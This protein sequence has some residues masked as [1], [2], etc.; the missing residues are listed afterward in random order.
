M[1]TLVTVTLL[2]SVLAVVNTLVLSLSPDRYRRE[3]RAMLSLMSLA[4]I[5]S[6]LLG[7]DFSDISSRF[8]DIALP[9]MSIKRDEAITSELDKK[10]QEYLFTCLAEKGIAPENIFI[11]TTIDAERR[12]FITKARIT[13]PAGY[14]GREG[15]I[16]SLLDGILGSGVAE[17]I[18]EDG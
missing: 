5:G 11:E 12:I 18:T 8:E 17:I 4:A 3:F 13:L 16:K 15:E 1:K 7:A 6:V 2:I 14:S 10:L 9:D